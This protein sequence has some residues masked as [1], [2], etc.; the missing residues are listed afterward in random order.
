VTGPIV[1][2][3]HGWA[4]GRPLIDL[5]EHGYRE[6]EFFVEGEALRY[7][8]VDGA[9]MTEDGV[10]EAEPV[11]AAPFRTRVLVYRPEDPARFNGTV[12]TCWNNVTAGYELFIGETPE[13]LAGGY[14]FAGVS[15]QKVGIHGFEHLNQGLAAW[16]PERYGSLSIPSDDYSYGIFTAAALA[17]GPNRDR[18][19]DPLGGLDVK[20]LI[21]MGSSQSAGRLGTYV[22]AIH[23]LT[24][25]FDGYLLL[26]YFGSGSPLEVGDEVINIQKPDR[27]LNVRELLRGR[28]R[29]RELDVPV[30]VVNSELEAMSC[31]PVRQPDTDRFRYWESAGTCH[32]SAQGMALRARRYERDFGEPLPIP[33]G[34]NRVPMNPLYDSALHHLNRWIQ[35]GDPP[36]S[37]PLLEFDGDE[38]VRDEDGIAVGGIRLPQVDV[39]VAT[40]SAVPLGEDIYSVLYGSSIPFTQEKLKERYGDAKSYLTQIAAAADVV[41]AA[42]LLRATD[43]AALV[44]EAT[45]HAGTLFAD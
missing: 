30:M 13:I 5:A 28:N 4:F 1:G 8:L 16:D 22:N 44:G 40:N 39:P 25:A 32:V 29:L 21:A 27:P 6:E 11:E 2:G 43:S 10:W 19:C 26:I 33:P 9:I 17:L 12:V 7:R 37:Q 31:L 24:H 41:Q 35:G 36:P 3:S 20:R 14:A 15:A 34:I 42:G 45:E 23:P 18:S 38:L